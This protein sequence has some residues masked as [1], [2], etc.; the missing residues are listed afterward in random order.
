MI[1]HASHGFLRAQLYQLLVPEPILGLQ[2][3]EIF[4]ILSQL[5]RQIV[6]A[7]GG[8][9]RR[10]ITLRR[11]CIPALLPLCVSIHGRI[12]RVPEAAGVGLRAVPTSAHSHQFI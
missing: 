9:L 8:L 2:L 6:R 5:P 11:A 3:A 1:S 7:H 12:R 10:G 4:L